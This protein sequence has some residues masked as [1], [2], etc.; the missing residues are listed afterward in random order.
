MRDHRLGKILPIVSSTAR[1]TPMYANKLAREASMRWSS[2]PNPEN[3]DGH[4]CIFV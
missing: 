3:G 4:F 1:S 2:R